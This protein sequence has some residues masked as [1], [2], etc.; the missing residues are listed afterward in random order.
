MQHF[1][2]ILLTYL[3]WNRAGYAALVGIGCVIVISIP[4]NILVAIFTSIHTRKT[5]VLTDRRIQLMNELLAGIQVK[6]ELSAE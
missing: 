4:I 5:S 2:L 3:M 1:Q 6:I